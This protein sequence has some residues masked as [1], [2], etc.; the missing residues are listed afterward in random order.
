MP[1]SFSAR[2]TVQVPLRPGERPLEDYLRTPERLVQVL[3]GEG[4]LLSLGPDLY[5]FELASAR[6]LSLEIR[7][8]VD[9]RAWWNEGDRLL[10]I[11]A[12]DCQLIGLE[13]LSPKFDLDLRGVLQAAAP[14]R[15]EGEVYLGIG[16]EL[17]P[18]LSFTPE[19]LVR[20]SGGVLLNGILGTVRQ[21]I[22]RR[23]P[24]DYRRWSE[25]GAIP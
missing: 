25:P 16:L 18:M 7:P 10:S 17:P 1:T 2:Q 8:L 5:R 21:K 12:Q 22:E 6:F 4:N 20:Q 9:L 24:E 11:Q 19:P 15:L 3:F 13:W 14:D 23:L